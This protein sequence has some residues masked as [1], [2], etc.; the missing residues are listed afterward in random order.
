LLFVFEKLSGFFEIEEFSI[1]E[2]LEGAGV[3]RNLEDAFHLV[4]LFANCF[5]EKIDI[6]HAWKF[7]AAW[8]A[9]IRVE[10]VCVR[11]TNAIGWGSW[12]IGREYRDSFYLHRG[13]GGLNLVS[14]SVFELSV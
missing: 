1:Y 10:I 7:T 14:L 8:C 9:W 3:I 13:V 2:N 6:Y 4:T 5:D 12:G 11:L